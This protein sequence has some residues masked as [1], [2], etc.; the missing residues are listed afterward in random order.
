M[1]IE[2]DHNIDELTLIKHLKSID[3]PFLSQIKDVYEKTKDILNNRV[4]CVFPNYTLHNTGHSFRIMEYMSKLVV[5]YKLLNEIEITLLVY[6]ALLHD[7]GMAMH[8]EDIELIKND[9][10]DFC[11][12]KF[13]AMMKIMNNDKDAA[14]QEY[15]RRI[16]ADLSGKYIRENLKSK[17]IIPGLSSLD[18]T[19]ELALICQSHTKDF[20]WIKNNL[21]SYEVKGDY[22]FNS[23]FIA[24]ILRL[25]DILDIDSN[26]TPHNLYKLIAPKGVSNQEWK[27]HFIISNNNKITLNEKTNQKRIVFHG[28]ATNPNIHRKLLN[29]IG[30]VKNELTQSMALVNGMLSQYNLIYDNNPEINIQ[31]EGYTFS[32]YKM[33]LE[34]KAISSLLMGEKIYGSRSLGLRELLQNSID[35]CRIRKEDS[36]HDLEF[37]EDRYQPKIKLILDK[38]K[39]RVIVKDNGTGMSINIIK[40]HFLNIGVSYYNSTDFLLKDFEFKPIGNY[41]IGFLA[42]FM[43]SNEV[44]VTTRHYKCKDKYLIELERENEW[45]SLTKTEDVVFDGTEVELNY[46]DFMETFENEVSNVSKFIEKYFLMDGIHFE[47]VDKSNEK[48]ESIDNS[49]FF[50]EE[51]K[52]NHFKIDL[53]EY[54]KDVEGYVLIKPKKSFI[55]SFNDLDFIGDVYTYDDENGIAEIENVEN[56]NIDD[57]ING[58]E[59]KYLSIPLI[60]SHLEDDFAN[61]MKFTGEDIDEVLEKMDDD[62]NWVSVLVPKDY[63]SSLSSDSVEKGDYIFDEFTFDDL[64]KIGH[65][66]NCSTKTEVETITLFEGRK[67][68]LYL[69]FKTRNANFPSILYGLLRRGNSRELFMRNVLIKD[70]KFDIPVNASTFEILDIKANINSRAFIPDISRNDINSKESK[71][72]NYIVGKAIHLGA[73]NVLELMEDEKETLNKFTNTFYEQETEFEK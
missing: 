52:Q 51:L 23:Q 43:L 21:K 11:E 69:P 28:K 26:R 58:Q 55:K 35:A 37:G 46:T 50:K 44:N 64:V 25:G 68:S 70:F 18:F 60:E 63:Q 54:L 62:L 8:E 19:E 72:I 56:L 30:W 36:D 34:F 53:N 20:D 22:S 41:G 42:C 65:S 12:I 45:T 40:N 32:D 31:T 1:N 2:F 3:S 17:L 9:S 73:N 14:L 67:N 38:E 33:T 6:S 39:D 16:H 49:I 5:D 71:V 61:G 57:Y 13:S 29:Y 24:C 7:I 10:Y 27:Q 48:I 15:V 66:S 4:Q 47:L 59:I